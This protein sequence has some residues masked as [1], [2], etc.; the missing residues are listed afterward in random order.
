M[1][2]GDWEVGILAA[3]APWGGGISGTLYMVDDPLG[4]ATVRQTSALSGSGT[5]LVD[6]DNT[7]YTNATTAVADAIN[8][9]TYLPVT[10]SDLG[11]GNGLL[12]I[13][14]TGVTICAV[15]LREVV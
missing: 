2:A 4:A 6:T 14:A 3:S 8:N 7:P 13:Y 10:I 5:V 1:P 15:A 12:Q 11:G 9:L